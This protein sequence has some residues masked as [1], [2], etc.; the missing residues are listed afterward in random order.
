MRLLITAKTDHPYL[1]NVSR[2]YY[3]ELLEYGVRIFE[4][5][6]GI[7]HAKVATFDGCWMMVGSANFDIRAM[8]LNFELN[9]LIRDSTHALELEGALEKNFEEDCQEVLLNEFKRRPFKQKFLESAF[10]PLAAIL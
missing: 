10:R 8:R 3:E 1:M 6:L 2:S 4:Y 7:N 9:L 5:G